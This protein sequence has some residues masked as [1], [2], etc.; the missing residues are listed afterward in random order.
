M[1]VI[2]HF[3]ACNLDIQV[4]CR[5]QCFF[6]FFHSD[7]CSSKYYSNYTTNRLDCNRSGNCPDPGD[8]RPLWIPVVPIPVPQ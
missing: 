6:V 1:V 2:P 4:L 5:L 3:S 8:P 7:G